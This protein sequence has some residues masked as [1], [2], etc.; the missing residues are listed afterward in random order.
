MLKKI[1]VLSLLMIVV[2]MS[3]CGGGTTAENS[4]GLYEDISVHDAVKNCTLGCANTLPVAREPISFRTC[5]DR[6]YAP[7]DDLCRHRDNSEVHE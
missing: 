4:R 2:A 1:L 5:V 6:C 3:G 7:L